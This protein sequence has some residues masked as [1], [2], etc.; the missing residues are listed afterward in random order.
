MNNSQ[1]ANAFATGRKTVCINEGMLNAPKEQI[2]AT[3]AHE[4]GHLAHKD[5]D[6]VLIIGVGNFIVTS[7]FL[8]VRM[9]ARLT[10]IFFSIMSLFIGGREG[11]IAGIGVALYSF[12]CDVI[13]GLLMWIW[14]KIGIMMVMKSNRANE[15]EADKFAL[16]LGY[17]N[18]LCEFL[19]SSTGSST[20][21][22]FANLL[23]SHPDKD[24]RIEALM[25]LGAT[26]SKSYG[27]N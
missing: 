27:T 24:D 13:I 21:G 4:I 3:L 2:K 11:I 15:F 7:I 6:L 14:T 19:D 17:G 23:S 16:N 18:A 5:T 26:Y 20:K 10:A 1:E 25:E 22:L 12:I 8:I 9:F